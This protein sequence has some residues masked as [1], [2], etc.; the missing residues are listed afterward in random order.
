MSFTMAS[1]SALSAVPSLDFCPP[2]ENLTRINFQQWKSQVISAIKGAKLAGFIAPDAEAPA[3]FLPPKLGAKPNYP[4]I[5][6]LEYEDWVAKDQQVLN[7]LLSNLSKEV[8]GQVSHVLTASKAWAAIKVIFASQSRARIITTGM[9]LATASNGSSTIAENVAKM[10]SL[11]DE[12]AAVGRK[13]EH[14][15]LVS[16]ILTGL[17]MDFNPVCLLSR[18]G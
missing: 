12:M 3:E 14:E 15:E 2:S 6:I 8:L 17:D 4:S 18:Q 5:L 10:K 9:A 1:S 13:L 16:Y 11:A 7:Y